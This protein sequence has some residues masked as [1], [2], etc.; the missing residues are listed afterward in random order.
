[1]NKKLKE[2]LFITLGA[3]L[4]AVGVYFFKFPNHYSFGGVTGLAI[5]ISQLTGGV[6]SNG[7]ANLIISMLLLVLGFVVLGR[8]CGLKTAYG[9]LLLSGSISLLEMLFP[10]EAP[11]TDAPFLELCYAVALPALG[12]AILFNL[13]ASTGGTDI[14]AMILRKYTS[15]N[16]GVAL[17]YS[18]TVLTLLVFFVYDFKTGLYSMLGLVLKSLVVD[19]AIENLNIHKYFHIITSNPDTICH[20]ITRELGRGATILPA[21]GAYSHS[22]RS[23]VLTVMNRVQAVQLRNYIRRHD[24]SAFILMTNTSQIVGRGFRS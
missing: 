6:I 3:L 12:A 2:Y 16:I 1:M 14:V 5:I 9:S 8:D 11:L 15:V 22:H 10:L 17:M 23:V 13:E 7:T 21:T 4:V 18:D 19:M 20:Y 24:P